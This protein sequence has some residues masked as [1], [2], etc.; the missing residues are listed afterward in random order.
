[1]LDLTNAYAAEATKVLRGIKIPVGRRMALI[2]DEFTMKRQFK[3]EVAW[4][5]TTDAKVKVNRNGN[6]ATLTQDGKTCRVRI[7]APEDAVFVVESAEQKPPQKLNK[8][9][10]R[11]MVRVPVPVQQRNL[12]VAIALMPAWPDQKTDVPPKIVPLGEWK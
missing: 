11:L 10:S 12:R 6:L 7:L 8:G 1:M 5:M 9:V 3:G 2:Q 4:G